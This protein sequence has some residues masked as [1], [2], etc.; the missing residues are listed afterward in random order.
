VSTGTDRGH[1]D[2]KDR[3]RERLYPKWSDDDEDEDPPGVF[4][5]RAPP[6]P[7][8]P[9]GRTVLTACQDP[10]DPPDPAVALETPVHL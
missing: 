3:E 2:A 7:S 5:R 8:A 4:S 10:S 6:D 1:E 9:L